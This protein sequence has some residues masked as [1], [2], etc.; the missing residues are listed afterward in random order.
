MWTDPIVE[1]VRATRRQL[2]KESGGD[3]DALLALARR[4]QQGLRSRAVTNV[5]RA[6]STT[7][8]KAKRVPRRRISAG[9]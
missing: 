5:E 9:A 8:A 7:A 1:E 3:I 6:A 2:F 4:A